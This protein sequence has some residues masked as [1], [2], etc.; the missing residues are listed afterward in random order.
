MSV[1][2]TARTALIRAP[3]RVVY[4]LIADYRDGH[5]RILPARYFPRLEAEQGGAGAGT[6]IRVQMRAFGATREIRAEVA[7][8]V[9]GRV[10][11]ETDLA[12]GSR[13]TFTV[14][15]EGDGQACRAGIETEWDATGLRGWIAGMI[16][17]RSLQRIHVE[18]PAR[19][20]EIAEGNRGARDAGAD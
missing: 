5:P 2:R 10:L 4:R 3:A 6:V 17:P 18:E 20:T 13:T 12:T 19:L 11:V 16:L 15:P 1:V 7:E 14:T 9:P 8:P